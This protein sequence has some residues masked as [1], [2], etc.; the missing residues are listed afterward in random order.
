MLNLWKARLANKYIFFELLPTFLLGL[1][2]FIFI[3]LMF[4]LLR[5][6]EF[7]LAHGVGLETI[8]KM[9][10]YMSISF[11][12][13][14][15][16]M[17]LVFAVLLTYGR[18]SA[19][20]EFIAFK[21]IGLNSFQ[22]SIPA[23]ALAVLSTVG[24]LQTSHS[25]APWGNREFESIV[26]KLKNMK[27][28]VTIRA[29]VFSE[30]F[31]DLVV[32]TNEIDS[33]TG[34]L[35]KVFIYDERN[36]EYPMTIIAKEGSLIQDKDIPAAKSL[37]RLKNGNIHRTNNANYTKVDF[38]SYDINLFDMSADKERKASP[39]SFS[40]NDILNYLKE[41]PQLPKKEV[42]R[43]ETEY[44]RRWA[45]SFVS[46]VFALVGVALGIQTNLRHGKSTG[47]VTAIFVIVFY[48]I[49]YIVGES[50]AKT[51][52]VPPIVAVWIPNAMFLAFALRK[53]L[54]SYRT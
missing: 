4:Q 17:S 50:I 16:P 2:V 3:L 33:E 11:L 14:I 6:T 39:L 26:N 22:L 10:G 49:L 24:A 9:M 46:L 41:N 43:F 12:P 47:F 21:S 15:L 8:L 23:L 44:H 25:L 52:S 36:P 30:G 31:F 5:L 48:W 27:A 20:S 34:L 13:V 32:Y 53:I 45:L 51:G 54:L 18:L 40:S 35:K 29:G 28:S 1:F 7:V 42:Y 19:D 37:L 38:Q